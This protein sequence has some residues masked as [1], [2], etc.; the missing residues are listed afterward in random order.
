MSEGE[1]LQLEK[2][3]NLNLREDIYYEIIKNKT[4]SLLASACSAAH[5]RPPKMTRMLKK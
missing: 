4:A 5:G 1:L 3:R 2:A